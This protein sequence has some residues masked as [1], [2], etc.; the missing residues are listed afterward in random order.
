MS[1]KQGFLGFGP[2]KVYCKLEYCI[3]EYLRLNRYGQPDLSV[4]AKVFL[5]YVVAEVTDVG[6]LVLY[7][8]FS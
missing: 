3:Y 4:A 1:V 7:Q 8:L 2:L 6:A 5:V